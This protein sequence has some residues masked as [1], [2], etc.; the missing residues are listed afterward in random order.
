MKTLALVPALVLAA[1]TLAAPPAAQAERR[2]DGGRGWHSES[3]GRGYAP[4]H[5]RSYRGYRSFGHRYY[6]RPYFYDYGYYAYPGPVYYDYRY[7]PPRYYL[8]H[9]RPHIGF[10]LHF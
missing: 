5:F 10:F 7:L 9:R 3:R 8:R 1:A 2:D 6:Y 4:R